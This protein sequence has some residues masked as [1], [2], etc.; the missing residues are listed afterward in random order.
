[1]IGKEFKFRSFAVCHRAE[2]ARTIAGTE[3]IL[4]GVQN[5]GYNG[6]ISDA[7]GGNGAHTRGRSK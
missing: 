6:I 3:P 5:D 2:D 4:A 1:M 7:L